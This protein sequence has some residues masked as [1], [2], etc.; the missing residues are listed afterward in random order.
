METIIALIFTF[1]IRCN[2]LCYKQFK[3]FKQ[4]KCKRLERFMFHL[5]TA[6]IRYY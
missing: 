6:L 4:L 2:I 3:Q 5:M 1:N